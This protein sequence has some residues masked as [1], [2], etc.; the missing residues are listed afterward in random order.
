MKNRIIA[1]VA[2]VVFVFSAATYGQNPAHAM[3][4]PPLIVAHAT[5]ANDA[6]LNSIP[7]VQRAGVVGAKAVE[8][9]IRFNKSNY[10]FVI[11]DDTVDSVSNGTGK[12]RD[13]YVGDLEALNSADFAP[14]NNASVY[15]QYN[16][17]G[18]DGKPKVHF[19]SLYYYLVAVKAAGIPTVILD[20]K[21]TPTQ[22]D[23]VNLHGTLSNPTF[24]SL[25]IVWMA[26]AIGQVDNY[27]DWYPNQDVDEWWY[28]ETFPAGYIRDGYTFK[29]RGVTTFIGPWWNINPA[30]IQYYNWFGVKTG[31]YTTNSADQDVPANWDRVV[32]NGGDVLITNEVIDAT[33]YVNSLP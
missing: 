19:Q 12:V 30:V 13:K 3:A 22:A 18:A 33:N 16:G 27:Q 32:K 1:L 20:M 7:G 29:N 2:A 24:A 4:N 26:N 9:D 11:H 28:I 10:P 8:M 14:W 5:M 21:D 17:T 25:N 6:P 23:A 31:E 15:P